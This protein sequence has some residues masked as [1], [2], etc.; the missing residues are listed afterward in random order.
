VTLIPD[1]GRVTAHSAMR[2]LLPSVSVIVSVR[3]DARML[4]RCLRSILRSDYDDFEV[5]A[6]ERRPRSLDVPR[7]LVNEFPTDLRLRYVEEP[8]SSVSLGRNTGLARA[9]ADVVVFIDDDDVVDRDWLRSSAKALVCESG[10]AC[11][12]SLCLPG[13]FDSEIQFL[14]EPA[15]STEEPGRKT[16]RAPFSGSEAPVLA[17]ARA[18]LGGGGSL[19][20]TT[21][22]AREIGGFD[23]ALGPST[24]ACGGEKLDLLVGNR[25]CK[26]YDALVLLRR[27]GLD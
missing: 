1:G 7:L 3:N 19:M 9:E 5:I 10:I 4:E 27:N 2:V 15:E 12:T 25:L 22:V 18:A 21:E 8:S 13:G 23:P 17:C 14:L 16:Y 24:L 11:V 20:I 26:A 6:V